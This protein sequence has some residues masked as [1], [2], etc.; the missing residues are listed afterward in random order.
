MVSWIIS[1]PP[2]FIFS[3]PAACR[4]DKLLGITSPSLSVAF[5]RRLPSSHGGN[6]IKTIR[7]N[8]RC[9]HPYGVRF[10]PVLVVCPW[11]VGAANT[12]LDLIHG[13][14]IPLGITRPTRV[15][16]TSLLRQA[17]S[18]IAMKKSSEAIRP[19]DNS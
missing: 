5:R 11:A 18:G 9:C 1:W 15:A 8:N 7:R 4:G 2:L 19:N 10:D 6:V 12:K 17:L 16:G 14:T 13:A 3:L